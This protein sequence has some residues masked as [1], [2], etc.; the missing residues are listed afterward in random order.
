MTKAV[1]N[2][3]IV[4]APSGAGKTSLVRLCCRPNPRLS[5]LFPTPRVRHVLVRKTVSIIILLIMLPFSP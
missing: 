1:G 5:C 2:I 4:V 3:Y